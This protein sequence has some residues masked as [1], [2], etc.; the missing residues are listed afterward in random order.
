M[1]G[2]YF[3]G[4]VGAVSAILSPAPA[5]P[6]VIK[7]LDPQDT[8]GR[9]SLVDATVNGLAEAKD[10]AVWITKGVDRRSP[11]LVL[12]KDCT[13]DHLKNILL[14][15]PNLSADYRRVIESLL[16]DRGHAIPVPSA[17]I[18]VAAPAAQQV[19]DLDGPVDDLN[20]IV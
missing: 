9:P 6:I 1:L 19:Q 5:N 10:S 12:L 18:T 2:S 20:K 13:S 14:N 7:V 3:R 15:K 8:T 4:L 16:Q 11:A 17:A